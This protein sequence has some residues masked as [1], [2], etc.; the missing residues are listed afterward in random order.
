MSTSGEQPDL[1][2]VGADSIIHNGAPRTPRASDQDPEIF[3]RQLAEERL[4]TAAEYIPTIGYVA[5]SDRDGA[6]LDA[7]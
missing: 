1:F 7:A 3:R 5:M 6:P 2:S 4:G